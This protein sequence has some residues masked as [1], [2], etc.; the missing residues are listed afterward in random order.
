[1]FC[2]PDYTALAREVVDELNGERPLVKAAIADHDTAAFWSTLKFF[3][4]RYAELARWGLSSE[5]RA[6]LDAA[7]KI[8]LSGISG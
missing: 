1:M 6:E 4:D 5:Q 3:S 7:I 2:K 8:E